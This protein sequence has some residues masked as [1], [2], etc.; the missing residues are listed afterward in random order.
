VQS[1]LRRGLKALP[2]NPRAISGSLANRR[3]S[4]ARLWQRFWLQVHIH[5]RATAIDAP[6][7][8]IRLEGRERPFD[9]TR[10]GDPMR[11]TKSLLA[12]L[13]FSILLGGC[14][15]G[16]NQEV[17]KRFSKVSIGDTRDQMLAA[18]QAPPHES[19][20]KEVPLA[21]WE[22]VTWIGSGKRFEVSLVMDRVVA[23]SVSVK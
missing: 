21:S 19:Q 22:S 13:L 3:V 1:A 10:K 15:D 23:K 18:M 9:K 4:S 5:F 17:E 6:S 14:K 8:D 16:T 12:A 7:R 20:R 11:L 2:R